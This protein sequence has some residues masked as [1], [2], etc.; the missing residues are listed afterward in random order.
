MTIVRFFDCDHDPGT[1]L[2][3]SVIAGRYRDKWIFVRHNDRE[4]WEIAGGHIEDGESSHDAAVR[5][6]HEETGSIDFSID[7]I[8][9]YSV[10][11]DGVTGYGRLYYA[12][13]AKMGPIPDISEIGEVTLLDDLPGNLTHP[14]IQP[15]IFARVKRFL[16]GG[17]DMGG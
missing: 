13:V 2:T 3:Y 1:R 10:E 16:E 7:C 15:H 17:K 14:D 5:E 8:S 4:T 11:K 12:E 6:F 9:T